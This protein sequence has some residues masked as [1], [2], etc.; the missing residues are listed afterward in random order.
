MSASNVLSLLLKGQ[1]LLA[2]RIVLARF[3]QNSDGSGGGVLGARPRTRWVDNYL[4]NDGVVPLTS[5]LFLDDGVKVER[6]E[7]STV[8]V[9][10]QAKVASHHSRIAQVKV[11]RNIEHSDVPSDPE[12]QAFIADVLQRTLREVSTSA[13][14]QLTKPLPI[15]PAFSQPGLY[16]LGEASLVSVYADRTK[17]LLLSDKNSLFAW[18]PEGG[19]VLQIRGPSGLRADGINTISGDGRVLVVSFVERSNPPGGLG[20]GRYYGGYAAWS[21]RDGWTRLAPS[22]LV[23]YQMGMLWKFAPSYDGRRVLIYNEGKFNGVVA[24]DAARKRYDTLR[25]GGRAMSYG[26]AFSKEISALS[27]DGNTLVTSD[28]RRYKLSPQLQAMPGG[29]VFS[30]NG[31]TVAALANSGNIAYTTTNGGATYSGG[32]YAAFARTLRPRLLRWDARNGVYT[33]GNLGNGVAPG[34]LLTSADGAVVA[35]RFA[36]FKGSYPSGEPFI[37]AG[38]FWKL[39]Q[40]LSALGMSNVARGWHFD[41]I[42]WLSADGEVLGG[43]GLNPRGEHETFVLVLPFKWTQRLPAQVPSKASAKSARGTPAK[44]TRDYLIVPGVRAG[45]VRIDMTRREVRAVLS[46]PQF[47]SYSKQREIYADFTVHYDGE[48]VWAVELTAPRYTTGN[49]LSVRSILS[50][51]KRRHPRLRLGRDQ[52]MEIYAL[53]YD[54]VTAGIGFCFESRMGSKDTA[55]TI[56]RVFAS[57]SQRPVAI[58][59]HRPGRQWKRL[60]SSE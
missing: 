3:F 6:T 38:R 56:N 36:G 10:E 58:G 40:L 60:Y 1:E 35:S 21:E 26:Q 52:P 18:T 28:G 11:L 41:S 27:P 42:T 53:T 51:I 23:S 48:R 57:T 14:R 59:V 39:P 9:D 5:A 13:P 19:T 17:A 46:K 31:E 34:P 49:G 33:L 15:A 12:A 50:S 54:D 22:R 16:E 32:D 4:A 55:S 37:W 7:T 29:V 47:V 25:V 43:S 8:M 24:Y 20:E 45:P 2:G 30:T 44:V